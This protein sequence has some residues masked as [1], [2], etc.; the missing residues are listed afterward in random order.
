MERLSLAYNHV[1]QISDLVL[2]SKL[3]K[4]HHDEQ[5]SGTADLC[6]DDVSYRMLAPIGFGLG[7][8]LE[9]GSFRVGVRVRFKVSVRVRGQGQG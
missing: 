5:R 8:G 1:Q 4:H 9:L 3:I 2:N 6:M 7:L